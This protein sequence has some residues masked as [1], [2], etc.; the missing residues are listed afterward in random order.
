V[1]HTTTDFIVLQK[2]V[3]QPFQNILQLNDTTIECVSP[4]IFL[5]ISEER[6]E[7]EGEYFSVYLNRQYKKPYYFKLSLC[8]DSN[9][10]ALSAFHLE[11]NLKLCEKEKT[12]VPKQEIVLFIISAILALYLRNILLYSDDDATM[13]Y[14]IFVMMCYFFPIFGAMLADSLLGKFR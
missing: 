10:N 12:G 2:H 3:H 5:K 7:G 4:F 13:I 14:H 6:G 8:A 9:I 11:Q 1:D